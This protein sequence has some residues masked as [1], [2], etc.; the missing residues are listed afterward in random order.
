LT[1]LS[2]ITIDDDLCRAAETA[3]EV[4]IE[5]SNGERRWCFFFTPDAMKRCGDW[6]EG[7]RVRFHIGVPHM[8][9][10]AELSED[11]I[12]RILEGLDLAG[13]LEAHTVALVQ[14]R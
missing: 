13:E 7:T 11:I 14:S 3:I 12:R 10:V 1:T 6:V 9:V 2:R 5:F 4:T 8:I